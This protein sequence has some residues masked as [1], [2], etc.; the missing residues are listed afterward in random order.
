M[1]CE[2]CD[3]PLKDGEEAILKLGTADGP[4]KMK[5]CADCERFLETAISAMKDIDIDNDKFSE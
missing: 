1:N 5:I 4:V 3:N 2:C